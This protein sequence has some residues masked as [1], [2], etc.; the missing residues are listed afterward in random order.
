MSTLH[1]KTDDIRAND[2]K[3]FFGWLQTENNDFVDA[4]VR[5][6]LKADEKEFP[7]LNALISNFV[8]SYDKLNK[9]LKVRSQELS[10]I[11]VEESER[12]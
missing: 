7:E 9:E 5:M 8:E 12:G 1:N 2:L 6:G 4:F 3:Y 11:L 10:D